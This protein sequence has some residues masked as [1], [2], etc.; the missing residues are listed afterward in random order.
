MPVLMEGEWYGQAEQTEK[1]KR[2]K[3]KQEAHLYV[4]IKLACEKHFAEQLGESYYFDLANFDGVQHYRVHKK[5]LFEEFKEMVSRDFGIAK[6]LQR[7][8]LWTQR[9]NGTTRIEKPLETG[10]VELKTVLD[11]KAFK[12]RNLPP[13]SEK[14]ALMTVKLFLE[15]PDIGDVLRPLQQ[16]ELL[17]F[18]KH[19]DP[20]LR[21]LAYVGHLFVE[22][23]MQ[24]RTILDKAKK[25]AGLAQ[26]ADV[27]GVEE[28]KFNPSVTCAEL[29]P[30]QTAERVRYRPPYT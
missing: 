9:Q 4:V 10:S 6:H 21:K 7:F 5:T 23:T 28:V 19:Y 12:E 2:Q 30:A 24:I 26:D 27:I 29:Q 15:T 25:L 1:E 20:K 16:S 22:K 8:W 18:V 3:E 14:N 13:A 17:I 11:L